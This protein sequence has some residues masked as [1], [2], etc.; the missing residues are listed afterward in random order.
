MSRTRPQALAAR[1]ARFVR[2]LSTVCVLRVHVRV[3]TLNIFSINFQCLVQYNSGLL[4]YL[5][6]NYKLE[7]CLFCSELSGTVNLSCFGS[8]KNEEMGVE[9]AT[10]CKI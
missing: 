9:V 1:S 2:T 8:S 10:Y 4:V 3:F 5:L 6:T 7:F